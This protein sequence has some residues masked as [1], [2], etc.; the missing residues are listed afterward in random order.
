MN[1]IIQ[2][3]TGVDNFTLLSSEKTVIGILGKNNISYVKEIWN[4]DECTV[5]VPWIIIRAENSMS[6]FFANDK[7]FK[8]HVSEGFVGSL[9]NGISIGTDIEDAKEIDPSLNYDDWNEDWSSDS[10]YWL[11]DSLD[12][13]KVISIT[14]FIK[15]ILDDDLFEKYEW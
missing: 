8:I 11:E 10:G 9:P 15:E 3:F 5:K 6:F 12:T 14:I 1:K 2:P 13:N 7:L 4:N